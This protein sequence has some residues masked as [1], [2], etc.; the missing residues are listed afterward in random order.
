MAA[1]EL[2]EPE[3][4]YTT[5]LKDKH[6]D[7]VVNFFD[8]LTKKAGLS[9]EENKIT[10]T[11]YYNSEKEL[12]RLNKK[13][14]GLHALK[15][16]FIILCFVIAG[17]FLLIF[18]YKP[19]HKALMEQ[20]K[21]QQEKTEALLREAWGQMSALN[22]LFEAS[23]PAKLMQKTTPL[24]E[25][26][27]IF[28][29][30]KYELLREK[31]GL[32]DNEDEDCSTLNLQS[33]SILGNP[34]VVFKDLKKDMI[35]QRYEGTLVITYTVRSGN[36]TY[37]R[38]QTLRAHVD[39]PKPVYSNETYLIYGNEAGN[40]LSFSR[41][42]SNINSMDDKQIEKYVRHHEKDLTKMAEKATKKGGTYTPLGNSEF[43]L[44]FGGLDRD[45]EIE[46]RL[47][48]TP[49]A[50]KSMLELLKSKVGFGDDFTFI[51][52]K[53]INLIQSAHSQGTALFANTDDFKGF[54]YEIVREY[55]ITYNDAYFKCLFFD[56]APLLSI[57]LYQQHKS[58]EY[59]Y[60]NN[61]GSNFNCFVHETIANRFNPKRFAHPDSDT[62]NILKTSINTM[63][64]ETDVVNV[65]ALG[66]KAVK[67]V[68]TVMTPGGDGRMHGVPV[69][70]YDYVPVSN[71]S[72]ITI[73]DL[74]VDDEI[75]FK[76]LG[77]EGVIYANGLVSGD[78]GINVDINNLKSLMKKD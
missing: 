14:R 29:V 52:S 24:I 8:E 73:S 15:V 38:T 32:W 69:T 68:T 12:E 20:I 49:L 37:T 60:K 48:F 42:P 30:K 44:F 28:D 9:V 1:L 76:G 54:D 74:G 4:L 10:C 5:Q 3:Q 50:Q 65:T 36:Q 25:M 71:T 56:F 53:G 63:T 31:Y 41:N 17:I 67:R 66:F 34:F 13:D 72:S 23:M 35:M 55:F 62:T 26:D 6:H 27:R 43:E 59:I 78:D 7:T 64:G 61:V 51:K 58:H 75:K 33:G 2:L 70:W 16:L 45:N 57:P 11:K 39:K 46:Y 47:L 22:N 77:K 19:K 18:V 21:S 40:N